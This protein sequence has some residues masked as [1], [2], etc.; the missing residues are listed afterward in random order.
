MQTT[1]LIEIGQVVIGLSGRDKGKFFVITNIIDDRFVE[2]VDGKR[3]R[4]ENPKKKNIRHLR[5]TKTV[6]DQIQTKDTKEYQYNNAY[7]RRV[8]NEYQ[9]NTGG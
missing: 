9:Q 8:L 7:I 1:K 3:R 4:L 5:L 6:I 2:I